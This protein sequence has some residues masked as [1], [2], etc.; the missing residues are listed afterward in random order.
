ML[1]LQKRRA[2][3]GR[4]V[5]AD[6]ATTIRDA[7]KG[8]LLL[9]IPV[10]RGRS[11]PDCLMDILILIVAVCLAAIANELYRE[12]NRWFAIMFL[13]CATLA[14]LNALT[15]KHEHVEKWLTRLSEC[16]TQRPAQE[17]CDE[18]LEAMAGLD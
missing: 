5:S 6:G 7:S 13:A 15:S 11:P 16:L 10:G 17:L 9:R 2:V 12:G 18:I 8:D 1:G 14:P 4:I 3:L